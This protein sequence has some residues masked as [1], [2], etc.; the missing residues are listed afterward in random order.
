MGRVKALIAFV[1]VIAFVY[2]CYV[3]GPPYFNNYK[4]QDDLSQEVRFMQNGG[5][6]DDDIKAEVVK[7]AIENDVTITPQQIHI[8]RV[9]KTIT[10]TVDYTV[11][12]EVPGYTTDLEFHPSAT[13]TLAM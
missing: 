7:K 4:F 2:V 8:V 6:S 10:V 13:N 3:V 12:V 11:H 9:N 5:K 1:I